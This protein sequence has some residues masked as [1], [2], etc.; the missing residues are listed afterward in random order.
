MFSRASPEQVRQPLGGPRA[1]VEAAALALGDV[2]SHA[3]GQRE[4][5]AFPLA[6]PIDQRADLAHEAGHQRH[7]GAPFGRPEVVRAAQEIQLEAVDVV[8]GQH[9]LDQ[10]AR[11][12]DV[13][14]QVVGNAVQ[15]LQVGAEQRGHLRRVAIGVPAGGDAV[16]VT[17]HLG[18]GQL[19]DAA[20][21]AGHVPGGPEAPE[22]DVAVAV[23]NDARRP[24][25]R[26]GTHAT[27]KGTREQTV[28]G[29]MP[30]QAAVH[31]HHK[32]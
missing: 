6:C 20:V 23:E 7:A 21:E 13:A 22:V 3:D 18:A 31:R 2:A 30:V 15:S 9:L 16:A 27:A 4:R 10:R 25:R 5:P 26:G 32:W 28:V 11:V 29:G 14:P 1:D 24:A 19:V 17:V 12:L 8:A